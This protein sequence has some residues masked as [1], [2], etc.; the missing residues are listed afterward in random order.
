MSVPAEILL[1]SFLCSATVGM[2]GYAVGM[3]HYYGRRI[4]APAVSLAGGLAGAGGGLA[5]AVGAAP[6]PLVVLV[7][8]L[9]GLAVGA[10]FH[11]FLRAQDALAA[12]VAKRKG[13]RSDESPRT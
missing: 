9:M 1:R 3:A 7:A 2:V 12:R 8:V 5:L 11:P 10:M 4:P 13:R 6:W